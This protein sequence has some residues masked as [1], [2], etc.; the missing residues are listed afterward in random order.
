[1]NTPAET[2]TSAQVLALC[3]ALLDRAEQSLDLLPDI[4]R[5]VLAHLTNASK[6][7]LCS[8]IVLRR[9]DARLT[10]LRRLARGLTPRPGPG[11]ACG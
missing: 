6:E 11:L 4:E 5:E 9:I 10:F 7:G 3:T 2:L 1:M 8:R